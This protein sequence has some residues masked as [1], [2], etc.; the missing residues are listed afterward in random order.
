M[1]K[2]LLGLLILVVLIS[3]CTGST[4]G[5]FEINV[6]GSTINASQTNITNISYGEDIKELLV[7]GNYL[8][9][10]DQ[11]FPYLGVAYVEWEGKPPL[12]SSVRLSFSC[13][14]CNT[15]IVYEQ[16]SEVTGMWGS[17]ETC[18]SCGVMIEI[19]CWRAWDVGFRPGLFVI[20]MP[21]TRTK[22]VRA[23]SIELHI[24]EIRE[25]ESK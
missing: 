10:D 2:V 19:S 9:R 3:G 17:Y 12:H 7:E 11:R 22:G 18:P 25:S 24:Q 13:H 20:A 16:S 4:T 21:G 1:K 23:Q 8:G 15:S 14:E 6:Q 5:N